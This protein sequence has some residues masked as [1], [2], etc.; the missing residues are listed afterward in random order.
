MQT[1]TELL[2]SWIAYVHVDPCLLLEQHLHQHLR[3]QWLLL[4]RPW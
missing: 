4:Q 1:A 3:Q 2:Q